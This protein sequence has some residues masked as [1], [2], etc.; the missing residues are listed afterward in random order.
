[1]AGARYERGFHTAVRK[2]L[3][4]K[5]AV[6][7]RSHQCFQSDQAIVLVQGDATPADIYIRFLQTKDESWTFSGIQSAQ[8]HNHPRRHEV[9]RSTGTPF[10]RIASQGIRGSDVDSEFEEVYDL[11]QPG[12]EPVF[13]FTVQGHQQRLGF[14]MSRKIFT[15]L[16]LGNDAI[17]LTLEVHFSGVDASGEHDFGMTSYQAAF[18]RAANLKTFS[19]QAAHVGR[20][21]KTSLTKDEFES[22][23]DMNEG[24]SDEDLI[25]FDFDGL[26]AVAS[27]KDSSSKECLSRLLDRVKNTKEVVELRRLLN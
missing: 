14:G 21:G 27:G 11:T 6:F 22:L 19:F 2:A 9:D 24:P 23:C 15:Y 16:S 20:P 12:F 4:W 17:D 26:K 1:M 8:I 18:K 3:G 7:H 10:L 13:S 5:T 25:R